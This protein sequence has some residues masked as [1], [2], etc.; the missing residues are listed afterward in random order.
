MK[1]EIVETDVNYPFNG[2]FLEEVHDK[3]WYK[4]VCEN[5]KWSSLGRYKTKEAAKW[6]LKQIHKDK[7]K[8]K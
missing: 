2:E 7:I 4:L 5:K 3:K 1:Y 8:G 6:V